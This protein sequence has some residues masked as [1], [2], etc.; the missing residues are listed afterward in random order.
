M[1]LRIHGYLVSTWT[2]TACM[3]CAEKGLGYDLVPVDRGSAGHH[4][5]H[6]FGRMPILEH[7]GSFITEGLAITCYLDEAF[8]GPSLQPAEVGERTRMREWMSRCADYAFRDVVRLIPRDRAPSQEELAVAR[9]VLQRLDGLIGAEPYLVGAG[10]T[11]AD[12]YLAPQV[13]NAREKAPELLDSLEA[14][15]GWFGRMANRE[16]FRR[17]SYEPNTLG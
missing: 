5:M 13:S 6:P 3:T 17:T 4:A 14:L 7:D 8:D 9:S 10:V 11:L 15:N 1:T 16:S 2:R 12:L